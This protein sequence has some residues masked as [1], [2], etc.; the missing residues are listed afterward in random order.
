MVPIAAGSGVNSLTRLR[1][2]LK[3]SHGLNLLLYLTDN[4]VDSS[5]VESSTYL[6]LNSFDKLTELNLGILVM[7]KRTEIG[8]TILIPMMN[9][10]IKAN[11]TDPSLSIL[12]CHIKGESIAAETNFISKDNVV[13]YLAQ[14]G[15]L[16]LMRMALDDVTFR[17]GEHLSW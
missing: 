14:I 17:D 1:T 8:Q 16:L 11:F 13:E 9:S 12:Q 2:L 5:L 10:K 4:L 15:L 7:T 3:W 6:P